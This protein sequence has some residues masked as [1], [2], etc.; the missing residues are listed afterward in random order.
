MSC[1]LEFLSVS[2][3]SVYGYCLYFRLSCHPSL[4]HFKSLMTG[5]SHAALPIIHFS[6]HTVT[7]MIIFKL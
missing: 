3:F 2:S 5:L 1:F 7:V 4:G 6:L